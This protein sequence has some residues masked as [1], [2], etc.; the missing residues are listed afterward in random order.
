EALYLLLYR[1]IRH[2][3]DGAREPEASFALKLDLRA[4]F[5]Q[6]LE[7]D[8]AVGFE[9]EIADGW[10]GDRLEGFA[11]ARGFPTLPD[12]VFQHGLTNRVAES[13]SHHA[14]R[15]LA[16]TKAGQSSLR[17]VILEGAVLGLADPLQ[18]HSDAK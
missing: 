14:N 11:L 10:I 17:G 13:L 6:Q 8:R 7:F 18:R 4:D 16:R 3:C 5:N 12:D 9:L 15:R 2:G 1:R